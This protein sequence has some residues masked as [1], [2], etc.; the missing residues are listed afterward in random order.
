MFS[1]SSYF[2]FFLFFT[3]DDPT[4]RISTIYTKTGDQGTS[5]LYTGERRPKT[6]EIFAALGDVDEL[7]SVIGSFFLFSSSSFDNLSN[8]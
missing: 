3:M 2:L 5:S 6:D 8:I 4:T 7:S 1:L